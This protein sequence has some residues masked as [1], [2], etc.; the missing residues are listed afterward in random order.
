MTRRVRNETEPLILPARASDLPALHAIAAEAF[1]IPWPFAEMQQELSRPFAVVRVLRPHRGEPIAGFSNHWRIV[2]ELQLMNIAVAQNQ[3]GLGY[4]RAL[5]LDVLAS[6]RAERIELVVLEVRRSN[7]AAIRLYERHG[8]DHVGVRQRYYSDNAEDA[9][10][11]H[12]R[13][14]PGV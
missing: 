2:G 5:L 9:L 3:R 10:V 8:F 6:A 1:P 14:D 11:M 13:V 7:H 4:G 12:L